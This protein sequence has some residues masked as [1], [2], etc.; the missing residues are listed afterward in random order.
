MLF[1]EVISNE[2]VLSAITALGYINPT[3]IQARA[4]PAI[5]S[6][7]DILLNAPEK[8]GKTIACLSALLIKSY[9][10][11][12]HCL[13]ITATEGRA[14]AIEERITDLGGKGICNLVLEPG[15][16]VD[17][18]LLKNRSRIVIG[19]ANAILSY[20]KTGRTEFKPDRVYFDNFDQWAAKSSE[21]DELLNFITGSQFI[22]SVNGISMVIAGILKK[23]S[24]LGEEPMEEIQETAAPLMATRPTAQHIYFEVTAELLAKPQALCD[25]IEA[26]ALPSTLVFC[27]MPSDT[28]LVKVI[29]KKRGI[30]ATKVIG[31]YPPVRLAKIMKEV[32]DG[33]TP[34]I[35]TTDIGGK[36]IDLAEFD[37]I[38]NYSIPTEPEIYLH[39][40]GAD[41]CG[42]KGGRVYSLVGPMD[43][44]N[45]HYL[46]KV[47]G[48]E[49]S[50]G[51]L[52]TPEAL[53]G[54][55]LEQLKKQA[56]RSSHLSDDKTKQLVAGILEA[57]N[58]DEII[59]LLL[60]N[61]LEVMPNMES[62][63]TPDSEEGPDSRRRARDWDRRQDSGDEEESEHGERSGRY[64]NSNRHND[65][66]RYNESSDRHSEAH[67]RNTEP[68]V[69]LPKEARIYIG[70]GQQH[71]I[72]EQSLGEILQSKCEIAPSEI[73]RF[74]S[75]KFYSFVDVSEEASEN[76]IAKLAIQEV[77]GEKLFLKKAIT[78]TPPRD[79]RNGTGM[80]EE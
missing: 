47:A 8:S 41:G 74:R 26:E 71:G 66:S 34:V 31:N 5:V 7:K 12:S 52:P 63:R 69:P 75:R 13:I 59:A 16:N 29:L 43:F 21:L 6:G 25:L 10:S 38:I 3:P 45:F 44:T 78:L 48:C 76:V 27:N 14:E 28:D 46:K 55:K 15:D 67:A 68:V 30:N 72:T 23:F 19:P 70:Q 1:S 80:E 36:N 60:H 57:T 40:I 9:E 62:S 39:R 58:R 32:K 24:K 51:Q 64:N 22:V 11:H 49:F 18:E 37:L 17:N 53:K 4:L 35:V 50:Q 20:F 61:T 79:N 42:G 56:S 65:S 77:N 33:T 2:K 54:A 73:K